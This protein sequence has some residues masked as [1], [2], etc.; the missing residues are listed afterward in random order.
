MRYVP[1]HFRLL[2]RI[3]F[4][5]GDYFKNDGD[6][7]SLLKVNDNSEV[8]FGLDLGYVFPSKGRVKTGVFLGA[9][10]SKSKYG[11]SFD[12][13][14]YHYLAPEYADMDND[15]YSRYYHLTNMKQEFDFTDLVI[16][17]YMD[18]DIL[19]SNSFSMFIDLG[20]KAHFNMN[21]K[22]ENSLIAETYGIYHSYDDL[23]IDEPWLN[24]FGTHELNS[25]NLSS[26][27]LAKTVVDAFANIGFR[28]KLYG[29]LYLQAGVSY[30]QGLMKYIEN[31]NE[32]LKFESGTITESSAL[33]TYSV[34]GGERVRPIVDAYSSLTHSTLKFNAGLVVKF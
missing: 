34:S 23:Y 16:P 20:V 22:I 10:I 32:K 7:V 31:T 12:D 2:P 19:F 1:K 27:D 5:M 21:S 13:Y 4:S 3:E 6:G 33:V 28:V 14:S 18:F 15:S 9:A 24:D 30:Q 17:V 11:L 29:P 8:N 25:D 26:T